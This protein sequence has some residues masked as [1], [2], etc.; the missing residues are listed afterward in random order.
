MARAESARR[1]NREVQTEARRRV[2]ALRRANAALLARA[3]SSIADSLKLLDAQ[4][5]RAVVVHRQ[6]WM[7]RTLGTGLSKQG[8]LVVAL[9]DDGA[10]ALGISVAEQPDLVVVEARLP[11]VPAADLLGSLRQFSPRSL[12][13]VQVETEED[14][15]PLL[16]AGASAVFSRR[17]PTADACARI[18]VYLRD[19]PD[20]HLLLM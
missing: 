3:E 15:A 17:V 13:A 6:E 2:G 7:L 19:R 1:E 18:G 10:D 9:C 5:P 8:L 20:G 4:A 12:L 11:T 14:V 16:A